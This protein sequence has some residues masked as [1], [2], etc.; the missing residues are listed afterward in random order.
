M[1]VGDDDG[2]L[3]LEFV[4]EMASGNCLSR[5]SLMSNPSIPRSSY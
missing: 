1:T 3:E 4:T 5:W 2:G